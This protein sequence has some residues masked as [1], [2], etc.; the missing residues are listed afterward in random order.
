MDDTTKRY[1]TEL[2]ELAL[3]LHKEAAKATGGKANLDAVQQSLE[4]FLGFID[5]AQVAAVDAAR[6]QFAHVAWPESTFR[7]IRIPPQFRTASPEVLTSFLTAMRQTGG[8]SEPETHTDQ[9]KK[10]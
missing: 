10:P 9:Q 2:S 1:L 3:R 7:Q 6:F 8:T 5:R 4:G